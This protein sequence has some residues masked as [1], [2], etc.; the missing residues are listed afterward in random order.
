LD[1]TQGGQGHNALAAAALTN[2]A[3]RFPS[4]HRQVYTVHSLN[5]AFVGKE[6]QMQV[7]ELD[8]RIG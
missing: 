6:M 1:D 4:P 5:Y 3:K 2:D 8:Q 7:L